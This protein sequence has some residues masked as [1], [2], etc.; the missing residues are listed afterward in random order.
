MEILLLPIVTA[1]IVLTHALFLSAGI[2]TICPSSPSILLYCKMSSCALTLHIIPFGPVFD[3]EYY[4]YINLC[5]RGNFIGDCKDVDDIPL[6]THVCQVLPYGYALD[7]GWSTGY[8]A[9]PKNVGEKGFRVHYDLGTLGCGPKNGGVAYP[10]NSDLTFIC[11]P[12]AGLGT[13]QGS[14]IVESPPCHYNFVWRSLYAC[15]ICTTDDYTFYYTLCGSNG[16]RNKIYYWKDPVLC[17]DGAKLPANEEVL[18]S[19]EVGKQ[20]TFF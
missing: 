5:G 3:G 2:H 4:Y 17:H 6:N 7:V 12:S 19:N 13:L 20:F 1:P 8:Y 15:P 11:D 10:R 16:K 9:I 14:S 18:A